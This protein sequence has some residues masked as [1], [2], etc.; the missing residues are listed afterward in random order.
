MIEVVA[1][2]VPGPDWDDFVARSGE[3]HYLKAA[4]TLLAR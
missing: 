1:A 3:S 2:D 4:W